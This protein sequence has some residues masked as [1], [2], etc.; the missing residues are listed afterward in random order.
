MLK[1]LRRTV[2]SD[3]CPLDAKETTDD[4]QESDCCP[5]DAQDLFHHSPLSLERRLVR[6]LGHPG[7]G[8][9]LKK[10]DLPKGLSEQVCK[11]ILGADIARLDAP[12]C[13]A[14]SDE[15]VSQPEDS[16]VGN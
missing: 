3:C 7:P 10:L 11:L 2:K 1:G 12:F 8:A 14:I 5:L 13:Q 15:V 16:L 6:K 4:S 9:K